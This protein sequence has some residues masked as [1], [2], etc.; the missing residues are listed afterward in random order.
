M[1]V[2]ANYIRVK[3]DIINDGKYILGNKYF[4]IALDHIYKDNAFLRHQVN[5]QR[6]T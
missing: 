5:S 1:E 4:F 2:G 6:V 3:K